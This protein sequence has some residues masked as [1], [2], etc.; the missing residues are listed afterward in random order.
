VIELTRL[1]S[2]RA[3]GR[4]KQKIPFPIIS[5]LLRRVFVAAETSCHVLCYQ[6]L[7]SSGKLLLLNYIVIRSQYFG[8]ICPLARQRLGKQPKSQ[9]IGVRHGITHLARQRFMHISE[10]MHS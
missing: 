9:N 6:P 2:Y 8:G 4:I 10:K 7:R 3:P 5:L 1:S